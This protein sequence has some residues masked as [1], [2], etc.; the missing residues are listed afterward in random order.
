M[1]FPEAKADRESRTGTKTTSLPLNPQHAHG[2]Q[3][4]SQRIVQE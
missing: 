2:L 4:L 3:P 1:C